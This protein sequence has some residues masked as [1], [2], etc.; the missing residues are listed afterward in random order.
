MS[1]KKTPNPHER[2]P[3]DNLATQ[4]SIAECKL[5]TR[6][7]ID[8][9][10]GNLRWFSDRLTTRGAKHDRSKLVSPE[11]EWFAQNNHKLGSLVYGTPEYVANLGALGDGLEHHYAKNRHHP[12][13]FE[14][15]INDMN[16]VDIVEM[17]CDWRASTTRN[18]N[19]N[20][21]RSIET[22]ADRFHIDSQLKQILINTAKLMDESD[23]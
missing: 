4:L 11:V 8:D 3:S 6:D 18:K 14:D 5:S 12:E 23:T 10:Q 15:G 20:L 17:F 13:H 1:E 7:H 21:L 19:G 2:S 16:L 22:N 9:V